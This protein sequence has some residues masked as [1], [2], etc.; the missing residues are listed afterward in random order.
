MTDRAAEISLLAERLDAAALAR[1]AMSPLTDSYP[2]DLDDAYAVQARLVGR[3]LSRGERVVGLKMGFTSEAMRRQMGVEQPN[4]GWLTDAMAVRPGAALD[5]STLI[6]PRVEPEV[7][8]RLGRD[9]GWPSDPAQVEAAV[10]GWAPALEIVDSRFHAY[11]FRG[12]DNT[13]DNSSAAAF[14]LGAWRDWPADLAGLRI[15]LLLDGDLV[16]EG[17]A[18]AVMGHPLNSLREAARMAAAIGRPLQ[19]GMI[20]LTGGVTSAHRIADVERVEA[21]F[22]ADAAVAVAVRRA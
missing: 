10:D 16:E 12:E 3:R 17:G 15:R 1:T 14:V 6:H 9:L 13:A 21:Q 4:C 20:V 8:L 5:L 18:E 11:R 7:A 2:L 19:A 22:G